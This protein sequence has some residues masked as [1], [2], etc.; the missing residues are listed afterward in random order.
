MKTS[1]FRIIGAVAGIL[2]AI[3]I[4]DM[5][6]PSYET[7]TTIST[8][9]HIDTLRV[10]HVDTVRFNVRDTVRVRLSVPTATD[11]PG[12]PDTRLYK[13][14]HTDSLITATLTATVRG[15][16]LDWNLNYIPHFPRYI[17]RTDT[18][19]IDRREHTRTTTTHVHRPAQLT[20][21]LG[22]TQ[23]RTNSYITPTI[24]YR[25]RSGLQIHYGWNPVHESHQV[26][27]QVPLFTF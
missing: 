22:L 5:C 3:A 17:T 27:F 1:F 18:V 16:L 8:Q 7:I 11:L 20:A 25:F 23:V 12:L 24:G 2:L 19:W 15:E 26:S 4:I 6:S 9:V 14:Q 13:K 10:T 21:G